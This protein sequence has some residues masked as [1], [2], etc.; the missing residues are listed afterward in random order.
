MITGNGTSNQLVRNEHTWQNSP[1]LC[2]DG[3]QTTAQWLPC[4]NPPWPHARW[5]KLCLSQLCFFVSNRDF[6]WLL[7]VST[8][9]GWLLLWVSTPANV[10]TLALINSLNVWPPKL[11]QRLPMHVS[12]PHRVRGELHP[13]LAYVRLSQRT[14]TK[15]G[16]QR[17]IS[18]QG[19]NS[20]SIHY[21]WDSWH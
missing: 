15:Q 6:S 9:A 10:L 1:L 21:I 17:Q 19:Q 16:F 4:A 5:M 8:P 3:M 14:T 7:R 20:R 2:G 18:R 11:C 13:S 12:S